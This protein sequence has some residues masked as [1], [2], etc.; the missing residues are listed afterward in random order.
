MSPT[1]MAQQVDEAQECRAAALAQVAL[2]SQLR[3]AV[4]ENRDTLEHLEDQWSS[5]AQDAANIIQSK[6][7]QLQMVTDYCQ[8][9]QTAKNAVDK[10]TTE[11]DA[12]QSP[13]K[14]SSKE[15]ERLGSLQR[16]MEENRTALGELLVTHSKLCPHL[17][18]YERAIAET[19][20]KN[21]QETWRVL[22]RTVESMLHHT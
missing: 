15:A 16:S 8:R 2:L 4:A 22:E 20:Q 17:T 10:A 18:R 7:A 9:I 6:E 5:A 21:L 14:S 12:L 11:L 13:Q 1:A 19:E 3:G